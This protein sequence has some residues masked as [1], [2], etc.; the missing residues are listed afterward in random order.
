MTGNSVPKGLVCIRCFNCDGLYTTDQPPGFSRYGDR[1]Y[2]PCPICGYE[3][4]TRSNRIFR[5]AFKAIR[6]WRSR[7]NGAGDD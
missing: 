1:Y 5:P 7:R 2:E 6:W 4:N 3:N